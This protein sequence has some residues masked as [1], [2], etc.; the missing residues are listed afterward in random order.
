[1]NKLIMTTAIAVL[2]QSAIGDVNTTPSSGLLDSVWQTKIEAD[3]AYA[4]GATLK[5]AE[6]VTAK[7]KQD[8]D[9]TYR[10]GVAKY[11]ERRQWPDAVAAC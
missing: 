10:R 6:E 9:N 7:T 4:N 2:S 5:N 3:N 8:A 1:M 11:N